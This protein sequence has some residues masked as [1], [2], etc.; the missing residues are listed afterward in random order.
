MAPHSSRRRR[1]YRASGM[2]SVKQWEGREALSLWG[3][4]V[5]G[6]EGWEG[7]QAVLGEDE[8]QSVSLGF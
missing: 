1:G 6:E 5:G 7:E 8:K 4:G 3:G 2:V